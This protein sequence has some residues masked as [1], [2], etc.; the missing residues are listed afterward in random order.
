MM[1]KQTT[2]ERQATFRYSNLAVDP[3][4]RRWEKIRNS[5]LTP[6][7]LWN[8]VITPGYIDG[9]MNG[10][11]MALANRAL[12]KLLW[13]WPRAIDAQ[14]WITEN[15]DPAP[16]RHVTPDSRLLIDMVA[17]RAAAPDAALLDIGCNCGRH[18]AAL[19]DQGFTNLHGIDINQRAIG[20][21][22]EWFPQLVGRHQAEA[23]LIQTYLPRQA[24][25]S[26]DIVFTRGATVELIHP[27]YPLVQ[28]LA[29]VADRYVILMIQENMHGYPRLWTWEFLQNGFVL[30]KLLRP[31]Q[32][33]LGAKATQE[34]GTVSLLVYRR[35]E[36]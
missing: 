7:F 22:S 13:F 25:R 3:A 19:A 17:E 29:R 14:R 27:S 15:A 24:D 16:Y 18:L 1:T 35:R 10:R 9:L 12:A 36:P 33:E 2:A 8:L 26:F 5:L 30:E 21:M 34:T 32:P 23:G 11:R 4:T 31:V 6:R 28:E 20:V